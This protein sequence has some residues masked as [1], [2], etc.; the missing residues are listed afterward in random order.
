MRPVCDTARRM[1]LQLD[2]PVVDTG[3]GDDDGWGDAFGGDEKVRPAV[4]V[5]MS[6]GAE[7][8][9][10]T[11]RGSTQPPELPVNSQV[12]RQSG[13]QLQTLAEGK[14]V[15]LEEADHLQ[16]GMATLEQSPSRI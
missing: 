7:D 16:K 13:P 4:A 9:A 11:S 8:G 6:A 3:W 10:T 15:L 14:D 2:V 5:G 1:A 12:A